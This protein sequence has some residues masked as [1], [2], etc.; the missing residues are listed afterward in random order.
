MRHTTYPLLLLVF[1]F[2]SALQAKD[3]LPTI[4]YQV[5]ESREV[6]SDLLV[7][8]VN[9][10]QSHSDAGAA[11]RQVNEAVLKIIE[12][13]QQIEGVTLSSG[14]YH[15]SSR[16]YGKKREKKGGVGG[17]TGAEYEN[18]ALSSAAEPSW[19]DTASRWHGS[20]PQLHG[21]SRS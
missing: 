14:G 13:V 15:T 19:R 9:V 5:T 20:E 3:D 16:Q 10:Q 18:P 8:S 1:L 11:S 12:L 7:A 2:S 21:L 6:E 17:A 4:H